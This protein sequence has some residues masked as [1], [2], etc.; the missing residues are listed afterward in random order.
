MAQQ[1]VRFRVASA[2]LAIAAEH[3]D[4]IVPCETPTIVPGVPAHVAGI[5]AV[6]GDAVPLLDLRIFLGLGDAVRSEDREPR[7]LVVRAAGYRVGLICD[8]VVGIRAI[9]DERFGPPASVQPPE[10]REHAR[11][12]LDL[13][14][15]IAVVLDLERMLEA[16]RA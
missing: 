7:V 15:S 3:V 9:G 14:D 6:R 8:L 16:A 5:V 12:Q 10:L 1:V 13:G 2:Q 4:E 11:A